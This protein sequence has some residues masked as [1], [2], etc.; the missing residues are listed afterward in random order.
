MMDDM[1]VMSSRVSVVVVGF[2]ML[3]C[4]FGVVCVYS[5]SVRF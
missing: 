3:L 2:F 4:Y 1:G 5:I